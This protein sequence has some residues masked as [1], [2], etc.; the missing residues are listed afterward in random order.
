M[1]QAAAVVGLEPR[2]ANLPAKDRQ[3]MAKHDNLEFLRPFLP[4]EEHDQLQQ[5]AHNDVQR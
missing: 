3:L 4:T 2:L 5:P 1:P